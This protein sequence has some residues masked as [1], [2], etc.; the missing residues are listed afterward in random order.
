MTRAAEHVSEYMAKLGDL[1][2]SCGWRRCILDP[3][4]AD[5]AMM[6]HLADEGVIV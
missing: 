3:V 2:C 6:R 5:A 1:S 4:E